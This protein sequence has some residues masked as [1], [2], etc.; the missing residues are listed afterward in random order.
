[1]LLSLKKHRASFPF[2]AL[3]VSQRDRFIKGKASV[4]SQYQHTDRLPFDREKNKMTT[5]NVDMVTHA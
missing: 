1:M 4:I 5:N 3:W 2:A